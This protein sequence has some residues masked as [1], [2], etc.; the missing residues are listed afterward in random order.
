MTLTCEIFR[1]F[2]RIYLTTKQKS[3]ICNGLQLIVQT[4]TQTV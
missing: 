1:D 3:D 4:D 2:S